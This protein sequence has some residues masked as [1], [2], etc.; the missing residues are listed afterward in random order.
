MSHRS[1][2]QPHSPR[3]FFPTR[4]HSSASSLRLRPPVAYTHTSAARRRSSCARCLKTN[5]ALWRNPDSCLCLAD[6]QA[7]ACTR[8]RLTTGLPPSE[9]SAPP[10]AR[11]RQRHSHNNK[12]GRRSAAPRQGRRRPP[13]GTTA[14]RSCNSA[15]RLGL[16]HTY[17][18]YCF[19]L[20]RRPNWQEGA[21]RA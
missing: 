18:P 8:R 2:P 4:K 1:L 11:S 21:T 20:Q 15:Q 12:A 7:R 5:A 3:R 10:R 17:G 13:Y 16:P 19:A 9:T 6:S 14:L